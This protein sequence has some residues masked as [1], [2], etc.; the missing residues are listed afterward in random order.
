M[1]T[2][3]RNWAIKRMG[4]EP[5]FLTWRW[6]GGKG[7]HSPIALFRTREE[8]RL[9]CKRAVSLRTLRAVR[10]RVTVEEVFNERP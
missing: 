2:V 8:A 6:L 9:A 10:V 1:K 7:P 4:L 3:K 5:F